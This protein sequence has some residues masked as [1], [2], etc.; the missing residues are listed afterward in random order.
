MAARKS[1]KAK[2]TLKPKWEKRVVTME[3]KH[4]VN[5]ETGSTSQCPIALL[6]VEAYESEGFT[7]TSI[8]VDG[9]RISFELQ[10][11]ISTD[12]VQESC[13][14]EVSRAC[15]HEEKQFISDFD[16][17]AEDGNDPTKGKARLKKI[18]PI[19]ITLPI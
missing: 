15:T 6:V 13:S 2:K 5:G 17:F 9:I 12:A 18:K 16:E 19:S 14:Y 4:I 10:R 8:N 1:K 11:A 7:V 3:P